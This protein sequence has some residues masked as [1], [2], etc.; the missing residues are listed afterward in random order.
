M[1]VQQWGSDLGK[2]VLEKLCNLYTRLV[3]E[4]T[5]LL[6]LCTPNTVAEEDLSFASEEL[7]LLT[8]KNIPRDGK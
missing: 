6:T 2:V 7:K 8:A 1:A 5:I 3:W 4:S